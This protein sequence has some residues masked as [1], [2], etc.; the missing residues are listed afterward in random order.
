MTLIMVYI[1]D[2]TAG[3][4]N[5]CAEFQDNCCSVLKE[6]MM[7]FLVFPSFSCIFVAQC[8]FQ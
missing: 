2:F 8:G 3:V 1:N 4:K 5:T 7:V 6:K